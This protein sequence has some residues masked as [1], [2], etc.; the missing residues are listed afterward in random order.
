MTGHVVTSYITHRLGVPP[1][2]AQAAYDACLP[3]LRPTVSPAAQRRVRL[4]VRGAGAATDGTGYA[5]YRTRVALLMSGIQVWP[6]RIELM[7]WSADEAELGL[8]LGRGSRSAAPSGSY[9]AAGLAVLAEVASQ[10]RQWTDEALRQ[11]LANPEC[12]SCRD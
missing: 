2:V 3:H 12:R 1:L 9:F 6:V 7:P 8:R 10:I 5:P 11:A 4:E